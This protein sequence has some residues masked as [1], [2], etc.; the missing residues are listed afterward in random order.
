MDLKGKR[1]LN[2]LVIVLEGVTDN[3][4]PGVIL[5][6]QVRII[7]WYSQLFGYVVSN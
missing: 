7:G 2:W 4:N 6:F 3:E 1:G 5:R